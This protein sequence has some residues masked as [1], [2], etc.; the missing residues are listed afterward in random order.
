MLRRPATGAVRGAA[1]MTEHDEKKEGSLT[2]V[3]PVRGVLRARTLPHLGQKNAAQT[4]Q[5]P[6]ILG[7]YFKKAPL[8]I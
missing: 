4:I 6:T 3:T 5:T 7:N 1:Y 8:F 2:P